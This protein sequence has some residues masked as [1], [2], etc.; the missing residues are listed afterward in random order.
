MV[1]NNFFYEKATQKLK[2]I[3]VM[4]LSLN[5][6]LKFSTLT[7]KVKFVFDVDGKLNL[8]IYLDEFLYEF[9]KC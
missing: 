3:L 1:E 8:Q 7:I 4:I 2:L 5:K 9:F 6:S